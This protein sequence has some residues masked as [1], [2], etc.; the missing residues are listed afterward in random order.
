LFRRCRKAAECLREQHCDGSGAACPPSKPNNDEYCEDFTKMCDTGGCNK[1]ICENF[2]M[3][4]CTLAS[5]DVD[6]MCQL[7]CVLP[8]GSCVSTFNL[9][10]FDEKF[11]QA[12]RK[13]EKGLLMR[14]GSLCNAGKG[15]CDIFRK[16]RDIDVNGPLL[17]LT[18]FLVGEKLQAASN[19][20]VVFCF[21]SC[22]FDL[23]TG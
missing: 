8:N 21:C 4:E 20:I 6:E 9:A 23:N 5:A 2:S 19:W 13:G 17:R 3:R 11:E 22:H 18:K 1:S 15:K 7:A 16:C 12:G 10:Q 14:P